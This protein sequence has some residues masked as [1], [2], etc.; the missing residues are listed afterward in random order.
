MIRPENEKLLEVYDWKQNKKLEATVYDGSVFSS[1]QSDYG[2]AR[3]GSGRLIHL[4][5]ERTA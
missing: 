1:L 4:K 3:E 2:G 5:S